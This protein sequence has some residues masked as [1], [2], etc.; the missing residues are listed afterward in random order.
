MLVQHALL[1]GAHNDRLRL[2]EAA[3][4]VARLPVAI[5]SSTLRMNVRIWDRRAFLISVRRAILRA[6]FLADLV[7]AISI[8]SGHGRVS[9]RCSIIRC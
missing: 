9:G 3:S 6:A 1:C 4:A 5:A 7:F 2:L 8:L